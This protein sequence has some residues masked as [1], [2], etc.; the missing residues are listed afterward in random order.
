MFSKHNNIRGI[1]RRFHRLSP[2]LGQ[3]TNAILTRSPLGHLRT[4]TKGLVRLACIRHAASVHPEPGSNSP[5]KIHSFEW[6][7]RS[8]T[9]LTEVVASYHFSIVKVLFLKRAGFYSHCFSLS[10]LGQTKNTDVLFQHRFVRLQNLQACVS[11]VRRLLS[12][13]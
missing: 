4:S 8:F 13:Q 3:V 1:S 6:I 11:D 2:S 7:L 12:C 10:R 5:Q 9:G